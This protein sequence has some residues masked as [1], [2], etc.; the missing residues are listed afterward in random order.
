MKTFPFTIKY[1]NTNGDI[2]PPEAKRYCNLLIPGKVISGGRQLCYQRIIDKENIH[3][4]AKWCYINNKKELF[5]AKV[6]L[7]C[8]II[9]PQHL[10]L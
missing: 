9:L 2:I 4:F 10:H 1:N 5:K 3:L 7:D 6:N 8:N